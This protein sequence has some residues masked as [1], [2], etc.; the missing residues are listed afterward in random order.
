MA[1]SSFRFSATADTLGASPS[2]ID[3]SWASKSSETTAEL[4]HYDATP[5][6]AVPGYDP[7]PAFHVPPSDGTVP[8][9]SA[10]V[11]AGSSLP[12]PPGLPLDNTYLMKPK[13]VAAS[14]D[15]NTFDLGDGQALAMLNNTQLKALCE[16]YTVDTARANADMVSNL[17]AH[18]VN[19]AIRVPSLV[20]SP[21]IQP[22]F[23]HIQCAAGYRILNRD[24]L[25]TAARNIPV[26]IL[27]DSPAAAPPPPSL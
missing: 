9:S 23:P 3:A 17:R 13:L 6:F 1:A 5:S 4:P 25:Q 18:P 27:A 26:P 14:F 8:P 11:D 16:K 21:L 15:P 24:M 10:P 20:S 12:P 2:N 19:L 7:G 22:V